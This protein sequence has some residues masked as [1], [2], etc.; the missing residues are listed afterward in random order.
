[1][2]FNYCFGKAGAVSVECALW[3]G[4]YLAGGITAN[5]VLIAAGAEF[6]NL[7]IDEILD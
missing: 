2:L 7:V 4:L 1:M 3:F 5:P 6:G